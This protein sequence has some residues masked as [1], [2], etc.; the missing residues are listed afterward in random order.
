M[1]TIQSFVVLGIPHLVFI[2]P[3]MH[4]KNILRQMNF[5]LHF[6]RNKVPIVK[7]N[8]LTVHFSIENIST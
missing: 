1:T 8:P 5:F 6:S 7:K 4:A 3:S 2:F